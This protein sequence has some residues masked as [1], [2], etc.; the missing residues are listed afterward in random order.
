[1]TLLDFP[2]N[3]IVTDNHT[4]GAYNIPW[5]SQRAQLYGV[6]GIPHVQFDGLSS[7]IGA[8]SCEGAHVQYRARVQMR[9]DQVSWTSP[10]AIDGHYII[11]GGMV[12]MS[13]TFTK[14]TADPITNTRAYLLVLED[15]PDESAYKHIVRAAYEQNIS[16]PNLGDE[17]TVAHD[18][19]IAGWDIEDLDCIA[20][21]QN[22][23]TREIYQAAHI[24]MVI[25]FE[26]AFD[27]TVV[28]IPNGNGTAEF[29]GFC[30]NIGDVADNLT[31]ALDNASGWAAEYMVEGDPGYHTDPVVVPLAVGESV[32]VWMRVATDSDVRIG[33]DYVDVTSAASTRT[34][35]TPGHVFNG[36]PAIMLVDDD[37]NRADELLIT[38]ALDDAGYLYADWDTY[39]EHAAA[40]P[41]LADLAGYDVVI[42]HNGWQTLNLLSAEDQAALMAFMDLG[43]GFILLS[44]SYL[45]SPDIDPIFAAD[46]LGVD[47]WVSNVDSFEGI[48]IGGD[49]ISDGMQFALTYPQFWWD[50]SDDV[51]PNA[52]GTTCMLSEIGSQIGVRA[53]NG[54]ARSVFLA[55]CLNGM[56]ELQADPN[57]PRTLLVRAIDYVMPSSQGVEDRPVVSLPSALRSL[58]PNPLSAGQA[59]TL[60]LRVSDRAASSAAR[61]DVLDL[62]GRLVRNLVDGSLPAGVSTQTWNGRDA[63]GHPVGAGVYYIKLSTIENTSAIKAVV[64]R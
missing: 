28:S 26:F 57:N 52:I 38:T 30:T 48:G 43:G 62:N 46:Y 64:I 4:S 54:V 6:Y 37:G 11:N 41:E 3:L 61:L 35:P 55:F 42:W 60:R 8:G 27:P 51:T 15:N 19:V 24:P 2:D 22:M 29:H 16:I 25:D 33:T 13:A 39:Y 63:R 56:D 23:T 5:T 7:I 49:P 44:Q 10:V 20:F 36:S 14:D 53:D 32:E 9:L 59:A 21:I 45:E 17:A 47:S 50:R 18:F 12:S 34:Q 1:M 58:E 31:F 40:G